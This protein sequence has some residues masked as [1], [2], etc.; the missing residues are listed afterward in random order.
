MRDKP[1]HLLE[2]QVIRDGVEKNSIMKTPSDINVEIV[3]DDGVKG[4]W[5]TPS[6][7]NDERLLFYCHGGGYVFGSPAT[8]HAITFA[9][10]RLLES[11]TFSLQYRLAPEHPFP[12]AVDDAVRAYQYVL[13]KGNAPEKITLGGDSAGGGLALALC[14]EIKARGLP[15]PGC[16]V[17]YSPWTD[18]SVSGASIDTNEKTDAM[19]KAIFIREGAKKVLGGADPRAPLASPLFGDLAGLPPTLIFASSSEILY[20]DST[21]LI[22]KLEEEGVSVETAIEHGLTHAWPIFM[23]KI[24]EAKAALEKTT[25]FALS[26]IQ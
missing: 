23:G 7:V 18:L 5:Q 24:P 20:H 9:L 26:K 6:R 1:I 13:S 8:H 21:R 16:L 3:D 19:F 22:E 12:A 15:M 2:P 14:L 10:A 4:E 25:T 17:L 11:K